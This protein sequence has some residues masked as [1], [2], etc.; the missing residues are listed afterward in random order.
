M[1]I[2]VLIATMATK[3]HIRVLHILPGTQEKMIVVGI[4]TA[5]DLMMRSMITFVQVSM[6]AIVGVVAI[7]HRAATVGAYE[8]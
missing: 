8:G 1:L 2:I 7:S 3:M 6:I 4:I 5:M